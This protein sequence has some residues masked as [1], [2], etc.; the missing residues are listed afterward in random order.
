VKAD[1]TPFAKEEMQG[2]HSES[3]HCDP[4]PF[5]VAR[6]EA[7]SPNHLSGGLKSA[8]RRAYL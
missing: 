3:G 7:I 6:H 1:L 4:L 2:P 8:V 5:V